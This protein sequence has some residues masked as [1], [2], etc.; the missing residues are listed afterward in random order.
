VGTARHPRTPN[1][2]Q[3]D[4]L[5]GIFRESG[6]T[7]DLDHGREPLSAPILGQQMLSLTGDR[8]QRSVGMQNDETG[9]DGRDPLVAWRCEAEP[10]TVAEA[11][12]QAADEAHLGRSEPAQRLRTMQANLTPTA[13]GDDQRGT[14]LVTKPERRHDVAISGAASAILARGESSGATWWAAVAND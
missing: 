2:G 7:M 1:N 4:H 8:S 9:N 11:G 3:Q 10:A 12:R 13:G 14:E 5:C 6:I